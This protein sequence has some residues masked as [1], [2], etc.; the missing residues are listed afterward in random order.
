MS[1]LVTDLFNGLGYL[2]EIV[3]VHEMNAQAL[4]LE[5]LSRKRIVALRKI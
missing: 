3:I 1:V 2:G 4:N 5:G